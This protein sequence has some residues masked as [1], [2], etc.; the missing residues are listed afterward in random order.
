MFAG[1]RVRLWWKGLPDD[2]KVRFRSAVK[3][4]RGLWTGL[5]VALL[6]SV[7]FAYESHIQ[8]CPITKRRR[9]VALTP[10]QVRA[11][12]ANF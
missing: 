4:R 12:F 8:E 3:K 6:A 11:I 10:D 1:K 7:A 9:F 5:G 2:D